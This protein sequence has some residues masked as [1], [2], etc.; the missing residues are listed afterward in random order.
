MQGHLEL[1]II[2]EYG[3]VIEMFEL[4]SCDSGKICYIRVPMNI[5]HGTRAKRDKSC[6]LK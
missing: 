6:I 3:E 5:G 4:G 1:F 2:N